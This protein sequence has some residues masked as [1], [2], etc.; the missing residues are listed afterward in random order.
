MLKKIKH[1]ETFDR[2]VTPNSVATI[3]IVSLHFSFLYLTWVNGATNTVCDQVEENV[4][5]VTHSDYTEN[6]VIRCFFSI[7]QKQ[8]C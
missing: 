5:S 1:K 8:N 7:T 4:S 3:F 6:K 2:H